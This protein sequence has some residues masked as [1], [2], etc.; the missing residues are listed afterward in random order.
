MML[1]IEIEANPGHNYC[2][3]SPGSCVQALILFC[4]LFCLLPK[5]ETTNSLLINVCIDSSCSGGFSH[6]QAKEG[7]FHG[8]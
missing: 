3:S 7:V 6:N 5:L 4:L 8:C 1:Y 2:V